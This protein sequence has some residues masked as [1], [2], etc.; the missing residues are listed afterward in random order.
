[1]LNKINWKSVGKNVFMVIS[2]II[3]TI[4]VM[5]IS[6]EIYEE[7]DFDH[8]ILVGIVSM[9]KDFIKEDGYIEMVLIIC[10]AY[11][12]SKLTTKVMNI[13]KRKEKKSDS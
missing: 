9:F 13:F 12:Y 6:G 11:C 10:I 3:L 5:G 4:T 2:Y 1:M 7:F 8:G